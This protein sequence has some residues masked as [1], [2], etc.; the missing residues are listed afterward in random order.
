MGREERGEEKGKVA[1]GGRQLNKPYCSTLLGQGGR[2]K[3]ADVKEGEEKQA[4]MA[5]RKKASSPSSEQPQQAKKKARIPGD[6]SRKRRT[7]GTVQCHRSN[8]GER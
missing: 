6:L 7:K 2:D 8:L 3:G 1:K 4:K 5:T